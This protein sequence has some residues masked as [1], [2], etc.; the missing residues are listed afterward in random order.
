MCKA[1]LSLLG[2]L[3]MDKQQALQIYGLVMRRYE[4]AGIDKVLNDA[5]G[6]YQ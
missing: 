3:G 5:F 6:D 2:V 1:L 4:A